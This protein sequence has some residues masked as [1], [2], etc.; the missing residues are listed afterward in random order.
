MPNL[1]TAANDNQTV[2]G[3]KIIH[4]FHPLYEKE[5]D[6]LNFVYVCHEHKIFFHDEQENVASIPVAWT[7][8]LPEDPFVAVSAGRSFFRIDDL[9]QLFQKIQTLKNGKK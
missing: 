5:F 6:I 8:F 1:Q 4:P 3:F 7:N 2:Q 9:I